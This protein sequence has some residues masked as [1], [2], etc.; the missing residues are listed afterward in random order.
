MKYVRPVKTSTLVAQSK[1]PY[2]TIINKLNENIS[3]SEPNK[4]YH[5]FEDF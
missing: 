2:D 4:N 3:N 5:Q 1:H